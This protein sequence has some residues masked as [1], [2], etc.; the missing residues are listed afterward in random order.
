MLT[1]MPDLQ[2]KLLTDVVYVVIN[3]TKTKVT[4]M[5]VNCSAYLHGKFLSACYHTTIYDCMDLFGTTKEAWTTLWL[6]PRNCKGSTI[7]HD[8]TVLSAAITNQHTCLKGFS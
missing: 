5:S 4:T 2:K 1:D 7:Q 8:M 3:S 6:A